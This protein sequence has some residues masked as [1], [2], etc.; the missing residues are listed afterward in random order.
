MYVCVRERRQRWVVVV[1]GNGNVERKLTGFAINQ[2]ERERWG[3]N[4]HPE[5]KPAIFFSLSE[6]KASFIHS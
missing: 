2:I 4:N 5:E 3:N 6:S 1:D